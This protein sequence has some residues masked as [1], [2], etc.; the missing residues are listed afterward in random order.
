MRT[1]HEQINVLI[2]VSNNILGEGL[3]K[4]TSENP[5]NK[6]FSHFHSKDSSLAPDILLFDANQDFHALQLSYP[7]AK[8]V[9]LDT[10]LKDQEIACLLVCHKIQGI[11]SP[12]ASIEMFHKALK[13]VHEGEIW[14]DQKHLKSLLG[15]NGAMTEN[16]G[17]RS[18]SEQDKKIIQL[19]TLGDKNREIGEKLCLSEHT[20]KA[21]VSR[22]FKRMN[23]S[24]RSQLVS[25]ARGYDTEFQ[26]YAHLA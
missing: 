13:V 17:V 7:E 16:G 19:I 2:A 26:Q 8:T 5:Q 20:I 1:D 4:I 14:I 24:N 9:L 23:V 18:L 3:Y 15:R 25:V 10:G 22:I 11:I 12:D 21:H 6:A